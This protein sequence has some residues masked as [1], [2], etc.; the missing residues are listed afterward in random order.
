MYLATQLKSF[1]THTSGSR[2]SLWDILCGS[3]ARSK[4]CI[5]SVLSHRHIL[6]CTCQVLWY[7]TLD[8]RYTVSTSTSLF[9]AILLELLTNVPLYQLAQVQFFDY[10]WS[11]V[12][13]RGKALLD[14]WF[15]LDS[16]TW[17]KAKIVWTK[18]CHRTPP[19]MTWGNLDSN[20]KWLWFAFFFGE[21]PSG[22]AWHKGV[23]CVFGHAWL[24]VDGLGLG[25]LWI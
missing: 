20:V 8:T 10:N 16:H 24:H 19:T 5:C 2:P 18:G 14:N 9:Q 23:E 17:M 12:Y 1:A 4:Q 25:N 7:C 13:I 3:Q 15:L 22:T 11:R 21:G 6:G